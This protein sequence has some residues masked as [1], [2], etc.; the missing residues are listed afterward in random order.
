MIAQNRLRNVV[1]AGLLVALTSPALAIDTLRVGLF[2]NVSWSGESAVSGVVTTQPEYKVERHFTEVGSTPGN[3]I[4]LTPLQDG[5]PKVLIKTVV[6]AAERDLA[7]IVGQLSATIM[8]AIDTIS[9]VD[10][11]SVSQT[12]NLFSVLLT[13]SAETDLFAALERV[14]IAVDLVRPESIAGADDIVDTNT[15][16]ELE[17][18]EESRE[19]ASTSTVTEE[20]GA[21]E[22]A[23]GGTGGFRTTCFRVEC[24]DREG[25]QI[26]MRPGRLAGKAAALARAQQESTI[27][28][29][30]EGINPAVLPV[31]LSP[32]HVAAGENVAQRALS[33]GGRI[34]APAIT[35]IARSELQTVLLEL[36]EAG[37]PEDAFQRKGASGALG[38][39]IVL[40]LGAPVGVNRIRFYPRNTVQPAP[41]YAF[42]S[43]FLRQFELML[44][45]GSDL[46]LDGTGRL[47]PQ[48]DDY[49]VLRRSIDNQES[50]VDV[51]VSPPQLV[52]FIRLKAISSFPYEIDELDA[53]GQG[54]ISRARYLSPVYDLGAPATWGAIS[55]IERFV[56]LGSGD[57]Q[58]AAE[59]DANCDV[60]MQE[61]ATAKEIPEIWGQCETVAQNRPGVGYIT[62][63]NCYQT[64]C[65]DDAGG[66]TVTPGRKPVAL[67]A[68]RTAQSSGADP[69]RLIIRTRTGNDPTPLLYWARN[70]E[71]T[72]EPE[73]SLSFSDPLEQLGRD[74]YLGLTPNLDASPPQVWDRGEITEDRTNWSPWS[75]PYRTG[76]LPGGEQVLSPGPRRYIQFSMEF[77]N[78]LI[79]AT[80]MVE[81]LAIEY[82]QPPIADDLIAEIFPREVDS[83]ETVPF[84]YA[85]RALMGIPGVRG[86]DR[87]QVSTPTRI[88]GID[89]IQILDDSPEE[90]VLDSHDIS[91]DISVSPTGTIQLVLADGSEHPLPYLTVST[92]GDTFG[93][94][95]VDDG[96]FAV[97]FPSVTRPTGGGDR[98]VKIGFRS[99]VLLYSTVFRGEARFSGEAGTVQR[100]TPGNASFLGEGDLPTASGITVLSPAITRGSLVGALQLAPNPFS[101][102]GDGINDALGISYD[103]TSVTR[104]ADVTVRVL[105]LSGRLVRELFRGENLSGHYDSGLQAELLWDGRNAGGDLV[106]PG[107]YLLHVS[108][109]GDARDGTQMRTVAVVY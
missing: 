49:S 32:S 64:V 12:A 30:P 22:S 61:F 7:N 98:L 35:N 87:L 103:I 14:N 108:V 75:A 58:T 52:R 83:F 5:R 88:L 51:P 45:D 31:A 59:I 1:L 73:R 109:E 11:I 39:F 3:L 4:D 36:I 15:D 70:V 13:F 65:R 46:V 6:V 8:A 89:Q 23:L 27:E 63:W 79:D 99:R 24:R 107:I 55:W 85:V 2:G 96:G 21:C 34:T 54:F 41:N 48:L 76:N 93:I 38:T 91:A 66:Q 28:L 104:A 19:F 40:D 57:E 80:K 37:G 69:S 102:N 86:F 29:L 44:H 20:W 90:R 81:Q 101:P 67:P 74:E 105:D 106:P 97:R 26:T 78:D 9:D 56:N 95:S 82:L 62:V 68:A 77:E 60:S 71:R 72:T 100:V 92:S 33:W 43:D 25:G 16:P 53:F 50:V 18:T 10:D 42:Q 94:E 17:C 47:V 84:T